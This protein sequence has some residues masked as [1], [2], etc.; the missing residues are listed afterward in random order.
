MLPGLTLNSWAQE[1][2]L[3]QPPEYLGE[4]LGKSV[5]KLLEQKSLNEKS[6]ET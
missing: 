1:I 6:T 2:F 4:C 5:F 3:L